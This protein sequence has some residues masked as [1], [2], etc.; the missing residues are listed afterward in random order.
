MR[1]HRETPLG[2]PLQLIPMRWRDW[3]RCSHDLVTG[4]DQ[5]AGR[6]NG[7]I[8]LSERTGGRI[9]W[10]G[11]SIVAPFRDASVQ[12]LKIVEAHIYFTSHDKMIR[13]I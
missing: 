1:R 4:H 12:S 10:I 7:G 13:E 2:Q 8:Q 9:A 3:C 11:K 5:R 6:S